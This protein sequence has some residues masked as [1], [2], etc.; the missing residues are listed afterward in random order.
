MLSEICAEIKNYFTYRTDKYPGKYKIEGGVIVPAVALPTDYFAIFGSRKNNGVHKTTDVL[1][2]E[3]EF[4][5]SVWV[6]SIPDDFLAL[7]KEFT[8]S[9][10]SALV[11]N[12][13]TIKESS[14]LNCCCVI[15]IVYFVL[16]CTY[17]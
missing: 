5:G 6:M 16:H 15:L 2:D 11:R 13:S 8:T 7:A 14:M 1:K 10:L 3:D 17:Q 12:L 9:A 4:V